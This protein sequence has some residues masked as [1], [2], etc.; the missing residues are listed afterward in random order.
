M[1]CIAFNGC[2]GV[3]TALI[4]FQSAQ[5]AASLCRSSLRS[6]GKRVL[7]E[8]RTFVTLPSLHTA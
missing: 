7:S 3:L 5:F 8:G 2:A 1:V 4:A 6:G